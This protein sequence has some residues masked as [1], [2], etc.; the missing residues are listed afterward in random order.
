MP[1][2][3]LDQLRVGA[4]A[5]GID[6]SEHQLDQ[7]DRFARMLV[8]ANRKFNLTRI[9]EP[10]AIV[11]N[12][13]LDS[14]LC[15]WALELEAGAR[16]IDVGTGA[17]FP[18]IPIKI[19][20]PDLR[21]TLLDA[22]R[23]KVGFLADA[24]EDLELQ[25]AEPVHG[26]AEELAHENAYRERYDAAFARAL[27]DMS[28]LA[29]LCLPLVRRGGRVVAMKGPR[30]EGEIDSARPIIERLGGAVER[31]VRAHIPGTD[32]PR[33]IPILL[34]SARTPPRYPRPYA[35]IKAKK[36]QNGPV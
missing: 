35:M 2:L 25:D 33:T 30:I 7:C 27:A 17:G 15:L 22:T 29:E 10:E 31:V 32:I 3:P 21:L 12:H 14:L 5:L 36:R 8:E 11:V 34:K 24:I 26:R 13:F 4:S 23:K 9:T 1:F 28:V 16:V 6:L 20:R 19:A 18:G